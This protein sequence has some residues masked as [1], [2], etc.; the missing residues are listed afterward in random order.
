MTCGNYNML[1]YYHNYHCNFIFSFNRDMHK[2][3][4]N[5]ICGNKDLYYV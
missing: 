5:Y 3:F 2:I 4:S 1:V